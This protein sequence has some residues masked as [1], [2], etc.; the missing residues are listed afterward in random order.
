MTRLLLGTA[1]IVVAAYVI[2]LGVVGVLRA[3]G[4]QS[5]FGDPTRLSSALWLAVLCA[6]LALPAFRLADSIIRHATMERKKER[7]TMRPESGATVIWNVTVHRSAEDPQIEDAP[8]KR[9]LE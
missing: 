9:D 4:V 3:S 2:R 7:S 6:L 1:I 5:S 8:E